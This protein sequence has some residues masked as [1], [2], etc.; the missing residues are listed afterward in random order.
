MR[1]YNY[2][3]YLE[4]L[5][6]V[7]PYDVYTGR[8]LEIIQRGKEAESRT[9]KLRGGYNRIAREKGNGLLTVH[10]SKGPNYSTFADHVHRVKLLH[11]DRQSK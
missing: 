10:K 2:R 4:G 7:I 3:R 9:L 1:T 8:H 11:H 6:D 5:G